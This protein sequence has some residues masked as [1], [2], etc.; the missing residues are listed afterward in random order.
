MDI[1]EYLRADEDEFPLD[2][3]V[4][5]GGMCSIFRRIGCIGDSLASGEFEALRADGTKTYHDMFEYSW[6]QYIARSTSSTVYNF[7]RGGMTAK[8]YWDTFA[9]QNGFWSKDLLCQ[10]YIIA[11]GVNDVLNIGM[12]VG[13]VNDID[14]DDY[15]NN[16]ETFAGYYA[17]IIQ[18]LKSMQPQAKF[19]F[20][21]MMHHDEDS[22]RDEKRKK[23]A[24]ALYELAKY[25]DNSYVIDLY[26][27]GPRYDAKY[28][29]IF[30]LYYH[31]NPMG[32]IFTAKMVASY[33][34]YIIRANPE[35]FKQIGFVCSKHE[36]SILGD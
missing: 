30:N 3:M 2:R 9:E 21:T 23:H 31:L 4:T 16:A 1:Y 22:A 33:I 6:G 10:A 17:R 5:D 35:D 29:E 36:K 19:F 28:Q 32:Y 14:L 26:N 15:N 25:F 11:L 8:E 13:S 24:E 27:Y 18:R 20:V 12:P 7:S 34:D